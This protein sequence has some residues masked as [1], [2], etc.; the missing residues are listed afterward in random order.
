MVL[1]RWMKAGNRLEETVP[2]A[3]A[4]HRRMQLESE[5]ATVYWSERLVLGD[6]C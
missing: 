2:L 6:S 3:E 1:I 5:G 4:R